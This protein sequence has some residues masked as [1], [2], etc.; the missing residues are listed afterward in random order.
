MVTA[1]QQAVR[2]TATV[3]TLTSFAIRQQ[4]EAPRAASDIWPA[5]AWKDTPVRGVGRPTMFRLRC[6]C[7]WVVAASLDGS[8]NVGESTGGGS[9][10]RRDSLDLD[11]EGEAKHGSD[12][13]D[14]AQCRDVL[15][16][17]GDGD[18]PD[19]VG[20]HQDFEAEQDDSAEGLSQ[21][22]VGLAAVAGRTKLPDGQDRRHEEA[23][24]EHRRSQRLEDLG[25]EFHRLVERHFTIRSRAEGTGA[26]G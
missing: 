4:S 16:G 14:D 7:S 19:E 6:L 24:K 1:M 25:D 17:R 5:Q 26:L 23:T 21:N 2:M 20:G 11:L 10:P 9:P 18:G 8:R 13:H 3:T 12:E 22:L 15:Q